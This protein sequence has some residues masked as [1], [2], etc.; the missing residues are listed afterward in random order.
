MN[1]ALAVMM[2]A[3]AQ[4][5]VLTGHTDEVLCVAISSDGKTLYSGSK[6]GDI[7]EWELGSGKCLETY[8]RSGGATTALALSP[9][10]KSVAVGKERNRVMM[11]DTADFDEWK[12]LDGPAGAI[13]SLAISP[14]GETVFL[15]AVTDKIVY[16]W[17][18]KEGGLP[19]KFEHESQVVAFA[20]AKDGKF[21]ATAVESGR[22]RVLA[23][24]AVE[25]RHQFDQGGVPTC[26][27]F[28]P[29]GNRLASGGANGVRVWDLGA[30][31]ALGTFKPVDRPATCLAFAKDGRS[32]LVGTAQGEVLVLSAQSGAVITTF[33]GHAGEVTA[34]ALLP[35]GK[36]VASA[37]RDKTIRLW[38]LP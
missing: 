38:N 26:V 17:R 12:V 21:M 29:D 1:L 30:D 34:L 16:A 19:Q 5:S 23:T 33:K 28:S 31:Q 32:L 14:N 3:V 4:G 24:E 6:D 20:L 35:D 15:T 8:F 2:V 18:P 11:L 7:K 36:T 22:V 25:R 9:D 37:S 27:A 13:R 10:G